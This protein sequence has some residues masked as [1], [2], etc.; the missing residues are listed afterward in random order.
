MIKTLNS[1]L[2]A[3]GFESYP[4][5]LCFFLEQE[6]LLQLLPSTQ[7]RMGTWPFCSFVLSPKKLQNRLTG[8]CCVLYV[9]RLL[10]AEGVIVCK[11][12]EHDYVVDKRYIKAIF[13]FRSII[14]PASSKHNT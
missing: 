1:G 8:G 14:P 5:Q 4:D 11:R 10:L 6:N 12:L 9:M 7:V 2:K 13:T 3:T